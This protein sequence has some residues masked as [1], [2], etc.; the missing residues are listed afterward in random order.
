MVGLIRRGLSNSTCTRCTIWV[1]PTTGDQS[2]DL[3]TSDARL[4]VSRVHVSKET[5]DDYYLTVGAGGFGWS[6]ITCRSGFPRMHWRIFTG[7]ALL[8]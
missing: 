5:L 7:N 4:L 8:R 3:A 6:S 1:S 2:A